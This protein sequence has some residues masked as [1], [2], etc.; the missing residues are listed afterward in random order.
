MHFCVLNHMFSDKFTIR[1]QFLQ[2]VRALK[3]R[4]VL[5]GLAHVVLL[6]FLLL[7]M[8]VY[9]F[10]QNAQEWHSSKVRSYLGPREWSPLARWTFREFNEV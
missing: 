4:L 7:F 3:A 6:P 5:V 10:L 8:V 2:D 1:T 9:F